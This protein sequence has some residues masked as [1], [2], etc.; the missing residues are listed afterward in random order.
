MEESGHPQCRCVLLMRSIVDLKNY[1][2]DAK[3]IEFTEIAYND[4]TERLEIDEACSTKLS[5]LKTRAKGLTSPS[6]CLEY[7]VLWR[8]DDVI[9]PKLHAPYLDQLCS[10]FYDVMKRL[11]DEAVPDTSFDVEPDIYEEVLQHLVNSK[12]K[13]LTFYGQDE[14]VAKLES[15]LMETSDQPLVLY[16][17]SGAGKST[18]L[19]NLAT[20]VII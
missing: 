8:Y 2:D 17:E 3:A 18:L 1:V 16:G 14:Y 15:Y 13:T 20:K 7:E 9:H 6:N 10:E 5:K 4:R 11:I 19:S 12:R